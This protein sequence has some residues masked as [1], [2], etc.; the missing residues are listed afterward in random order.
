MLKLLSSKCARAWR[1]STRTNYPQIREPI[2]HNFLETIYI[3]EKTMDRAGTLSAGKGTKHSTLR[4]T[5]IYLTTYAHQPISNPANNPFLISQQAIISPSISSA[6]S[7]SDEA[8]S[9]DL[10]RRRELSPSSYLGTKINF[11]NNDFLHF[12]SLSHP[13]AFV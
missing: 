3:F 2:R 7:R 11:T 8:D 12:H 9:A 5:Y 4:R 10:E 13:S 6:A 1:L